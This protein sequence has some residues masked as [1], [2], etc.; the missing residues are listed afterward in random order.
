VRSIPLT[1]CLFCVPIAAQAV[2]LFN[3]DP[4]TPASTPRTAANTPAA[5]ATRTLPATAAQQQ[6]YQPVTPPA[7]S[8]ILPVQADQKVM[9]QFDRMPNESDESYVS[10]MRGVYQRS[11]ADFERASREN[12]ERL[13]AM[14][15]K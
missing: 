12:V 4:V 9:A 3:T 8:V 15:P 6:L 14:A 5:Q 2:G 1:I 11:A 13:K 7:A 10:R